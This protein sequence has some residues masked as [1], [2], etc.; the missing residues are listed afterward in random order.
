MGRG[1]KFCPMLGLGISYVSTSGYT[2][3]VGDLGFFAFTRVR[4][5]KAKVT[6]VM[7]VHPHLSRL[8]PSRFGELH[9][10]YFH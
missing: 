3:S 1:S 7:S 10:S 2:N 9:I 4:M 8:L 6:F 5:L